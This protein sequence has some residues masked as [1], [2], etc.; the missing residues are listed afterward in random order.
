MCDHLWHRNG[1]S[2]VYEVEGG[3]FAGR[4]VIGTHRQGDPHDELADWTGDF[5]DFVES[6]LAEEID[7]GL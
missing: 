3:R 2:A 5:V 1:S 7:G 6:T 4:F